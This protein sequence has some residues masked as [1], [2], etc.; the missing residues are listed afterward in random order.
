MGSSGDEKTVLAEAKAG[1]LVTT[2]KRG[3][4]VSGRV[5]DE[6]GKPI[7]GAVI[8]QPNRAGLG[9]SHRPIARSGDDGRFTLPTALEA[10]RPVAGN[11]KVLLVAARGYAPQ[12]RPLEL[13]EGSTEP[14]EL[15]FGLA[16]GKVIKGRAVDQDG[17]PIA[18]AWVILDDIL[19]YLP[20][21]NS[22]IVYLTD[23]EGRFVFDSAPD[24]PV[25]IRISPRYFENASLIVSPGDDEHVWRLNRQLGINL[26]INDAITN[27]PIK[28]VEIERGRVDKDGQVV[29]ESG[30]KKPPVGRPTTR[31]IHLFGRAYI[32]VTANVPALK[33]RILAH[34]YKPFETRMFSPDEGPVREEVKLERLAFGEGGGPSGT[35]VDKEGKPLP[36]IEVMLATQ[37]QGAQLYGESWWPGQGVLA[38]NGAGTVITDEQGRFTFSP[39]KERYRLA[40]V[41]PE[42]GYGEVLDEEFKKDQTLKLLPWGRVEGRVLRGKEPVPQAWVQLGFDRPIMNFGQIYI[43]PQAHTNAEGEFVFEKVPVGPIEVEERNQA[44][45]LNRAFVTVEPGKTARVTIGGAGRT[46]IGRLISPDGPRDAWVEERNPRASIMTDAPQIPYPENSEYEEQIAWSERWWYSPE[47]I[48]H[49]HAYVL[50]GVPLNKDGSFRID[51]I[52][53]GNYVFK[54]EWSRIQDRKL[55]GRAKVEHHFK[56]TPIADAET[57]DAPI[58]LGI[59][60]LN[61]KPV[62]KRLELGQQ[63]PA[64]DI[65]TIDG[66]PLK[67]ADLRGKYVLLDFWAT[68][69]GPCI[70]EFPTLKEATDL[71][72]KDKRIAF[73]SLSLD[74]EAKTVAEFLEKRDDHPDTI[75]GF[76]GDWSEDKVSEAYGVEAIPA[77]FLL[78]PEGKVIGRDLRGEDVLARLKGILGEPQTR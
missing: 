58:D 49:R 30:E 67:L 55:I 38:I 10:G 27:T 42:L 60:R 34:G 78:D 16:P 45:T 50:R 51:D 22:E 24:S 40:A 62:P 19:G 13:K 26:Q 61:E 73:V 77:I 48:A 47:G 9:L 31:D 69:C 3:I 53:P 28:R 44:Q 66:Q 41:H 35:V 25:K 14:I 63:A 21:H 5:L 54:A 57:A 68:W 43:F 37:S 1:A 4:P 23:P 75:Q 29:W 46:V 11:P 70:A 20:D 32:N 65:K 71:Y 8:S 36:G 56:V 72:G 59:L 33:L 6:A 18:Y 64:F 7:A 52:P 39:T 17:K 15:E 2:L 76:L 74:K 12:A